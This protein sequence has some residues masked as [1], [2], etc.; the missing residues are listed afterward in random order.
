MGQHPP[1]PQLGAL[2]QQEEGG[3]GDQRQG[4]EG[5]GPP[6]PPQGGGHPHRPQDGYRPELDRK[7]I[8]EARKRMPVHVGGVTQPDHQRQSPEGRQSEPEQPCPRRCPPSPPPRRPLECFVRPKP[9][10]PGG[11]GAAAQRKPPDHQEQRGGHRRDGGD[12]VAEGGG[13]QRRRRP[14]EV[15]A[16]VVHRPQQQPQIDEQAGERPRIGELPRQAGGD[17][18]AEDVGGGGL[19]EGVGAG[20]G[21][22]GRRNRAA[23]THGADQEISG[24]GQSGQPHHRHQLESR[25][26]GEQQ[27]EADD[28]QRRKREVEVEDREPG[29]PMV[30]PSDDPP[31]G[32]QHVPQVGG[33]EHVGAHVPS[34]GGVGLQKHV[35]RHGG[36]DQ[37]RDRRHRPRRAAGAP[38]VRGRRTEAA[39]P[40]GAVWSHVDDHRT[41]G[42]MF[43]GGRRTGYP[44]S[45]TPTAG[46]PLR[47]RFISLS[48]PDRPRR[49]LTVR[50][51]A[52]PSSAPPAGGRPA[53]APRRTKPP[54]ARRRPP[55]PPSVFPPPPDR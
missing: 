39:P 24:G 29:E 23:E 7:Q 48:S 11:Q 55:P 40:S 19:H 50:W 52:G 33:A 54:P 28:H 41:G 13:R 18:P 1:V 16:V 42:L 49:R 30:R 47:R 32:Q 34:G 20:G 2:A 21:G 12:H 31:A 6:G 36:Q 46:G 51:S 8:V 14:R 17:G 44:R 25:A 22:G 9:E 4:G 37:E 3:Q 10:P 53:G 43:I 15:A 35:R 5:K 27:I 45:F 26:V 38:A